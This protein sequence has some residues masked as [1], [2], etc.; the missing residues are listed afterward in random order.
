[1]EIG[2]RVGDK[3]ISG[4][5][6]LC[7]EYEDE[8]YGKV[9]NSFGDDHILGCYHAKCKHPAVYCVNKTLKEQHELWANDVVEEIRISDTCVIHRVT[10]NASA[11]R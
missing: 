7:R 9:L 2:T 6:M 5:C 10:G 11:S 8:T 1:M 3:Y 4:Y